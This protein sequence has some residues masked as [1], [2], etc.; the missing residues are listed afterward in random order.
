MLDDALHS[1]ENFRDVLNK[2]VIEDEKRNVKLQITMTFG[3]AQ[4][5]KGEDQRTIIG[6]VDELLYKGK[7]SG[8]NRIIAE[9][10]ET[11]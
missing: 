1:L 10:K 6:K 8:R 2:Q 3:I 11:T 5:L 7:E 4:A 9:G